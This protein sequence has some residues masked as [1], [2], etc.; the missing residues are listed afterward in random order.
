MFRDDSV[1]ATFKMSLVPPIIEAR[2]EDCLEPLA[3]LDTFD[4][5]K[6]GADCWYRSHFLGR[7]E[8]RD[9]DLA[10]SGSEGSLEDVRVLNIE[11]IGLGFC[12]WPDPEMTASFRIEKSCKY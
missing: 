10:P 8:I 2:F 3:P 9:S 4:L 1:V 6:D 11:L 12:D 7:H 5:A